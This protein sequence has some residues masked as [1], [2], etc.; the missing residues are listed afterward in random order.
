MILPRKP[1][2]GDRIDADW[3]GRLIAYLR[4]ITLR[5]G[6]HY[7]IKQTAGGTTL[8]ILFPGGREAG[9]RLIPGTLSYS[10]LPTAADVKNALEAAYAALPD[11]TPLAGDI[12]Y[13]TE[14]HYEVVPRRNIHGHIVSGS[15]IFRVIF[16]VNSE[17]YLAFQRGPVRF[18]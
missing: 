5:P 10:D 14:Y 6:P 1:S 9:G 3:A 4:S 12:V 8:D 15:D 16:S 7:R 2:P 13:M 17:E 18:L 11:V